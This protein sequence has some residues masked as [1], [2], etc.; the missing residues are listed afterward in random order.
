MKR[1]FLLL[2]IF[3]TILT[4]SQDRKFKLILDAGHGGKDPGAQKNGCVEKEIAL[5]VIL[6]IGQILEK[7]PDFDIKYTRKTDV[8][9]PLKDRAKIAN[10]FEANLFVSVH[11]NSSTSPNPYGSMTLVMGLSRSNLNFEIAKTENAVIFQEDDYKKNYQGFDPNN[12]STQIGLKILQEETL[13]QSISFASEVQNQFKNTLERKD[14]GMHQQPLWVLDATV[15]PGVL[16][17]LGF[18]SNLKESKYINSKEGR[19]NYAQVIALAILKYKN[20]L[21][22]TN[23]PLFEPKILTPVLIEEPKQEV[24]TIKDDPNY[25]TTTNASKEV[26]TEK[27]Y[28]VQISFS[29]KKLDLNPSNFNG[30]N[31]VVLVEQNNGYKYYYGAGSTHEECKKKL[32]EAKAKG[33]KSAFIVEDN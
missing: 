31:N 11:C 15:M 26:V 25:T 21:M 8:F 24:V 2:T 18:L 30:L 28:K 33:Y 16:I 6:Q 10:D 27:K 1:F 20:Q 22:E 13:L 12:P 7:Y 19:Q 17:E 3:F 4:Y 23:T 9:I 14:L 32:A 29:S 5:D